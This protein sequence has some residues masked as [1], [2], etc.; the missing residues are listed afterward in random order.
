MVC[1]IGGRRVSS[2]RSA[3]EL[4]AN[5]VNEVNQP[6]NALVIGH[7]NCATTWDNPQKILVL[8]VDKPLVGE[9]D[10][11]RSRMREDRLAR[12]LEMLGFHAG[13]SFR[14][15]ALARRTSALRLPAADLSLPDMRPP[16]LPAM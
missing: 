13:C 7:A 12:F 1:C 4:Q 8:D 15:S 5:D 9:V 2:W 14:F 3:V 11:K 10:E 6:N 16:A